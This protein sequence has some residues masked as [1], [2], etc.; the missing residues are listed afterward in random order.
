MPRPWAEATPIL[1]TPTSPAR[2]LCTRVRMYRPHETVMGR[3]L[4]TSDA[5]RAQQPG[6]RCSTRPACSP[7]PP[8]AAAPTCDGWKHAR[9]DCEALR[10]HT[11]AHGRG[12]GHVRHRRV[13]AHLD[14]LRPTLLHVRRGGARGDCRAQKRPARCRTHAHTRSVCEALSMGRSGPPH[15]VSAS[16]RALGMHAGMLSQTV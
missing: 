11:R 14:G 7:R 12:R 16:V 6:E 4:T 2:H 10:G 15:A 3:D 5:R 13:R 8:S 9:S 1:A